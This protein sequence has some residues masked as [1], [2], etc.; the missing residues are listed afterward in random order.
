M[1]FYRR[2]TEEIILAL[3]LIM[4]AAMRFYNY[5]DWGYS[6]DE[7]S[8]LYGVSMGDFDRMM[9][10]YVRTDFHPAGVQVFMYY[11]IELCNYSEAWVRLPFV[12]AGAV[13]VLFAYLIAARWFNKTTGLFVAATLGFLGYT[14]LYSQLARPYGAGLLFSLMAVYFWT[15][16]LF[17]APGK[18]K[19]WIAAGWAL[20]LAGCMYTHYFSF[21]F[22]IM[23]GATGLLFLKKHNYLAYLIPAAIA[24]V[25]YLPHLDIALEQF[26]RGGLG[27]WLGPP[28]SDYFFKYLFYSF[29]DSLFLCIVIILVVIVSI[30]SN[31][32]KIKWGRFRTIALIWFLVPFLVGY[33]Y[34]IYVNPVLQYSILIFSFPFLIIL[35]FSFFDPLKKSFN[36]LALAGLCVAGIYSTVIESKFYKTQHFGVFKELA[37]KTAE[38]N[39]KYWSWGVTQTVN[40]IVPYYVE[41]YLDRYDTNIKYSTYSTS[42]PEQ[43]ARLRQIVDSTDTEYFIHGWSNTW[44]PYETWEIIKEKYP[45]VVENHQYFNSGIALFKKGPP[46]KPLHE[47]CNDFEQF[48]SYWPVDTTKIIRGHSDKFMRLDSLT[49][50]GGGITTT[51]GELYKD[52]KFIVISVRTQYDEPTEAQIVIS[53]EG[54]VK[55][56]ASVKFSDQLPMNK[57]GKVVMVRKLPEGIQPRD[58]VKI[59]I[60]KPG[61][62]SVIIDDFCISA[63]ADSEYGY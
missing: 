22:A 39:K 47:L 12:V 49:E 38:W 46:R 13:S 60:W 59:Y 10:E 4:S 33:F 26:G 17:D 52:N 6:N 37:E 58:P 61:K 2:Y 44:N 20:S 21:L 25:L 27:T 62:S 43:L 29:N 50:F 15:R 42:A 45:V 51:S 1:S 48:Y 31:K 14:I 32:G 35:L 11:W 57:A 23:V 7:L 8:A 30:I 41:Y 24:V 19:I 56:W 18:K 54:E 63:Y 3:I 53:F 36:T 5:S 40:V 34:S 9:N 55:D 28:E 16:I